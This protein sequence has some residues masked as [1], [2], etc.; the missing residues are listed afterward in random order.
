MNTS[1]INYDLDSGFIHM[2]SA[3]AS[4]DNIFQACLM[5]RKNGRGGYKKALDSVDMGWDWGICGDANFADKTR[6]ECESIIPSFL[7]AAR[8]A[9][10]RVI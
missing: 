5:P 1:K 8:K 3:S 2:S 9:G 4:E 6:E 10:I 7:A